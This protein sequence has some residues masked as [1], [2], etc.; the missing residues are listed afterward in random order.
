MRGLP[1]MKRSTMSSSSLFMTNIGTCCL[2]CKDGEEE[3]DA[4]QQLRD[5]RLEPAGMTLEVW[6]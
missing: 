3:A 1:A 5:T 2:P 4:M 6:G